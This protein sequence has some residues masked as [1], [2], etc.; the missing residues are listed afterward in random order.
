[1]TSYLH[2]ELVNKRRVDQGL[3]PLTNDQV[4]EVRNYVA[5]H[6]GDATHVAVKLLFQE[7]EK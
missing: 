5:R 4:R 7:R 1:M 2:L 3:K 6:G